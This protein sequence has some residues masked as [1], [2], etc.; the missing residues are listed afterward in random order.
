MK[1]FPKGISFCYPWRNY[2]SDVLENLDSHL[3]NKHLHLVAPPGSGK[4]VLGLEVMLRLNQPTLIIAPTLAIRNQWV[5]RFRDLFLQTGETPD[6]IS[7]DLRNPKFM[8]V[9]TYQGLHALFQDN[10]AREGSEELDDE[11]EE[12]D[13]TF[14]LTDKE[15]AQ[16]QFFEQ[17]FQ[18]LIL[19][20]AHHLRTSWWRT[21]IS[22]KKQLE[23]PTI[24][25]LTATP[26]YDVGKAEWDKYI[27]LC[28]PIDE[29]IEVAALVKEGD[30]CPHQDYIWMSKPTKREHMPME[31][32]HREADQLRKGLLHNQAFRS[33]LES[34]PWMNSNEHIE[35]KLANYRYFISMIIYLKETGSTSW[36]IPFQLIDENPERLPSFTLEWAEELLTAIFYRDERMNLKE[37][38]LKS[39]RKKLSDIGA[40]EHRRVKLIATKAMERTLLNS[41]SKLDSIVRIVSLEKQAK[42]EDLR[43]VI[44]ADY[45]YANDLPKR[46]GDEKPLIRLG[47]VPIF[48]K[49]R[50]EMGKRCKL[51]VLTGS[52]VIIPEEAVPLLQDFPL[53]LQINPLPHDERYVTIQANTTSR[54][55]V[56]SMITEISSK[57]A[58]DVLVG[59]TALLGEGWDAPSVNT[60]ILASNVGTFM[61]TNQM[62][63]RAI[64]T[65][66]GNPNKTANIW[67]LVCI[68]KQDPRGGY[69]FVSLKRRF[70]SLSGLDEDLPLITTGLERLRLPEDHF[71][72]PAVNNIM[73][74][75][76]AD[77]K[78]LFERWQEAV[79]TGEKKR[80]ELHTDSVFVPRPFIFHNTLKATFITALTLTFS[81][82]YG[83]GDSN[84]H[85]H[86][87]EL[88]EL[89]FILLVGLA[90]GL[91]IAAP[92]WWKTFRILLFNPTIESSMKQ[93]GE[94]VYH[95]L[96]QMGLIHT[97][98]EQNKIY[99]EKVRTGEVVCYL[100]RGTNYE[101][102][103]FI[104]CLQ[105]L[106]D[107]IDNPRYLLYRQSGK[108]FWIRHDY[109]A[110]PEEI[111]RRKEFAE[112]LC[113]E[114]K[115]RVGDAELIFTRK[116]EGR[117]ALL[118]ARMGAMSANFEK[119]SVRKNVW[120]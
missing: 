90:I 25:A 48:E 8:T 88:K 78:R 65:E 116:P 87:Q 53:E 73:R 5:S 32:F 115:K 37:E 57:G 79:Q 28:G 38:P 63:G 6:W 66:P 89:V 81:F 7:T 114:W 98:P 23:D 41:V 103:L 3:D 16:K 110:V 24:V 107:P 12:D 93:V 117:K 101:Q 86:P 83:M 50:R 113:K 62:R 119:R 9:T 76:A 45:I 94:A 36:K 91:I 30:L 20:E 95:S 99:V 47:V 111:G 1:H 42:Q 39:L 19:D 80:E 74:R 11:T 56:V 97:P 72:D 43:L 70:R 54:Q 55:F 58:I 118:K 35:E 29:E 44:L 18:T 31:A 104:Q 59:T 61:L 109:H 106:T 69:D 60:L 71:D 46:A 108:R 75:R 10:G 17:N 15:Q 96:H 52:V 120:R 21:C 64:R 26:P 13:T 100:N 33:L 102:K 51:G 2:Q 85:Y 27:E 14:E 84:Y 49:L 4:T 40:F 82:F 22:V 34:H 112:I 105:E 67:H 77:R 92:Y 68:D